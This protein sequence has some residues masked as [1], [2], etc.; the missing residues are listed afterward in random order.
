MK[1][2]LDLEHPSC[3]NLFLSPHHT[4][5]FCGIPFDYGR[6]GL[7]RHVMDTHKLA[8]GNCTYSC[9]CCHYRSGRF[10]SLKKHLKL[11]HSFKAPPPSTAK[12]NCTPSLLD[13]FPR[14]LK[15]TRKNVIQFRPEV[16]CDPDYDPSYQE[17]DDLEEE[18][19][20][21]P[22]P[23]SAKKLRI[24]SNIDIQVSRKRKQNVGKNSKKNLKI[25]DKEEYTCPYCPVT[26]EQQP[27]SLGKF[28][29]HVI[30]HNQRPF[31]CSICKIHWSSVKELEKNPFKK[32]I[33]SSEHVCSEATLVKIPD[34]KFNPGKIWSCKWCP[35]RK[36]EMETERDSHEQ[37]EHSS[38]KSQLEME[39][40]CLSCSQAYRDHKEWLL[41]RLLE[42]PQIAGISCLFCDYTAVIKTRDGMGK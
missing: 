42:H 17:D 36:F 20:L 16:C 10:D 25:F 26:L 14:P 1:K 18:V 40:K 4:C 28:Y 32:E 3:D 38:L 7:T 27:M 33:P 34:G 5:D 39:F 19:N 31:R 24:S 2:H 8:S 37:K 6:D 13:N 41:H 11:R 30:F 21:E 12:D 15:R 35:D 29:R 22:K 9:P 23:R